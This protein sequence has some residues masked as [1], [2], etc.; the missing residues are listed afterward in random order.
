MR[1]DYSLWLQNNETGVQVGDNMAV[2][3]AYMTM[4][5]GYKE[6]KQTIEDISSAYNGP[7]DYIGWV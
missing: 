5:P 7:N 2:M 4:I 3:N 6:I 1:M